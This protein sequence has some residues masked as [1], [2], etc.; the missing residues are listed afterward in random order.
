MPRKGGKCIGE[1]EIDNED[2]ISGRLSSSSV[3][4]IHSPSS[5]NK[6]QLPHRATSSSTANSYSK[7]SDTALSR[8]LGFGLRR[9]ILIGRRGGP[10]TPA[11]SWKVSDSSTLD[12]SFQHRLHH[13]RHRHHLQRTHQSKGLVISARKLAASLWELQESP[14]FNAGPTCAQKN[15]Q[16]KVISVHLE[17]SLTEQQCVQDGQHLSVPTMS[18]IGKGSRKR[19]SISRKSRGEVRIL[20]AKLEEPGEYHILSDYIKAIIANG[21]RTLTPEILEHG[22]KAILSSSRCGPTT[23]SDLLKILNHVWHLEEQHASSMSLVSTLRVELDEARSQLQELLLNE[24]NFCKEVKSIGT[25]IAEERA[26]WQEQQQQHITVAIRSI[27]QDLEIERKSKQKLEVLHR[28]VAKEFRL[29]RKSLYRALED[30]QRE[31]KAR[32]LMEEVC[33][34]LAIEIGQDKARVEELKLQ[35]AKVKEEVEEER[36]MLQMAEIWRE[37]R[38]QLKLMEAKLELEEKNTAFNKLRSQLE[39]FLKAKRADGS[40]RSVTNDTNQDPDSHSL[41][42]VIGSNLADSFHSRVRRGTLS[43]RD[44]GDSGSDQQM[45]QNAYS[46]GDDDDDDDDDLHSIELN[47]EPLARTASSK[48]RSQPFEH[49]ESEILHRVLSGDSVSTS[50]NCDLLVRRFQGVDTLETARTDRQKNSSGRVDGA[51]AEG[52]I[53]RSCRWVEHTVEGGEIR[54]WREG[55]LQQWSRKS[56][57]SWSSGVGDSQSLASESPRI[58]MRSN[59]MDSESVFGHEHDR[60]FGGSQHQPWLSKRVS[61]PTAM[62]NRFFDIRNMITTW[63]GSDSK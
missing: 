10:S 44:S 38:V 30:L 51:I 32:Q 42:I 48:L 12:P 49:C 60:E 62:C 47:R 63:T 54:E 56:T 15:V 41:D 18:H 27:M 43:G 36:K 45:K 37:E 20:C 59:K 55:D 29:A 14:Y 5:T 50:D 7:G 58:T 22:S 61:S 34:E 33:D 28:K 8:P 16:Q 2:H 9:A 26:S 11:P 52:S 31:R 17:A 40:A 24:K 21:S 13:S 4:N 6:R 3:V 57:K 23:T 46:D 35:S 1:Q 39:A 19:S 53:Q 25:R